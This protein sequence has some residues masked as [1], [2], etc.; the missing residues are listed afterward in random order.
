MTITHTTQ[1]EILL[2][3]Y[4]IFWLFR[5]L[6]RMCI[7]VVLYIF[8]DWL[9]A[10]LRRRHLHCRPLNGP[11]VKCTRTRQRPERP[12]KVHASANDLWL[13]TCIL[14]S[15]TIC[16]FFFFFFFLINYISIIWYWKDSFQWK[17]LTRHRRNVEVIWNCRRARIGIDARRIPVL[18]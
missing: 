1:K 5:N 10:W 16:C 9:F 18:V 8:T 11:G 7:E 2:E 17:K 14:A 15:C 12:T 3:W 13:S 4:K 6:L